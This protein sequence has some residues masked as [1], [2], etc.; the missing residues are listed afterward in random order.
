MHSLVERLWDE[1][2]S[3]P[4]EDETLSTAECAGILTALPVKGTPPIARSSRLW[5]LRRLLKLWKGTAWQ[6]HW[7]VASFLSIPLGMKGRAQLVLPQSLRETAEDY[8]KTTL[9]TASPL[10]SRHWAWV[11]GVWGCCGGL[12]A[13]KSGYYMVMRLTSEKVSEPLK[14]ILHRSRVIWGRRTLHGFEE[15]ILR[16]QQKIVTFLSKLGLNDISLRLEEK[17][18]MRSIRDSANRVRNCDTANIK[19][20]LKAAQ[21]QMELAQKL[22]ER[23][24]L[25][26]L[27]PL[28]RELVE[29][30]LENPDASLAELGAS[31]SPP[32]TKSTVKYRWQ[33]LSE[34][35]EWRA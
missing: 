9:V 25:D 3:Y 35:V 7:N 16:D 19:R 20:S 31:L 11:R 6:S 27:P 5:V 32:V 26:E 24:L 8:A 18:I 1:W 15:L 29:A 14:K 30:R 34:Y 4:Q 22:R 17:A 21:E 10:S 33:R 12:Y 2:S 28:M 23:S 13:P